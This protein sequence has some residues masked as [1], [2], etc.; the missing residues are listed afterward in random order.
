MEIS[1]WGKNEKIVRRRGWFGTTD[2]QFIKAAHESHYSQKLYALIIICNVTFW[3][4][5]FEGKMFVE[6]GG[7]EPLTSCLLWL[8]MN[9][10][11]S[12]SCMQQRVVLIQR[13]QGLEVVGISFQGRKVVCN[14]SWFRFTLW[15]MDPAGFEVVDFSFS[16]SCRLLQNYRE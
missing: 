15:V 3:K 6:E 12:K 14:K 13:P 1:F 2:F 5:H 16:E 4:S 9:L 8:Q 10:I 7:L 11:I